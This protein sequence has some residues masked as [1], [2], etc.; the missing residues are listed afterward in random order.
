MREEEALRTRLCLFEL[1]KRLLVAGVCAGKVRREAANLE[2]S[3]T[4]LGVL[5][6]PFRAFLIV[7]ALRPLREIC[8]IFTSL[9]SWVLYVTV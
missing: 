7:G 3:N 5:P 4:M 9:F 2:A 6:S 8:P 1:V